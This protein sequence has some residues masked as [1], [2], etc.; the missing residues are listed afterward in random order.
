M[1]VSR[2]F[3]YY[4]TNYC[5]KYRTQCTSW[6]LNFYRDFLSR[7]FKISKDCR[8][9]VMTVSSVAFYVNKQT[10]TNDFYMKE[11]HWWRDMENSS[12]GSASNVTAK[13]DDTYTDTTS[14]NGSMHTASKE[15]TGGVEAEGKE[16]VNIEEGGDGRDKDDEHRQY[17]ESIEQYWSARE[18]QSG[19]D[20]PAHAKSKELLKPK[21]QYIHGRGAGKGRGLLPCGE[22]HFE[23]L[24]PSWQAKRRMKRRGQKLIEKDLKAFKSEKV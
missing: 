23:E 14:T 19:R 3:V 7:Q 22:P 6:L 10:Y 17:R 13:T 2:S 8:F 24:H 9:F 21:K 16:T 1:T 12:M 20:K 11:Y 4:G 18:E 15:H 5:N